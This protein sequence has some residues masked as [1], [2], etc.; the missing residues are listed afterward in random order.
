MLTRFTVCPQWL[1]GVPVRPGRRRR[2]RGRAYA[3][4]YRTPSRPDPLVDG[5]EGDGPGPRLGDREAG[6]S[7]CPPPARSASLWAPTSHCS[8]TEIRHRVSIGS[9][10]TTEMAAVAGLH[11]PAACA[12]RAPP[13]PAAS[14]S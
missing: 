6:W 5:G 3:V 11:C 1:Q 10:D 7:P 4:S 12:T 8:G 2:H 14:A 9:T 13:P